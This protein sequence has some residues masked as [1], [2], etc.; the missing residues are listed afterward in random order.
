M[1]TVQEIYTQYR[2]MPFLQLHQLRVAGVASFMAQNLKLAVPDVQRVLFACL[3]H[4]MGN[5]IK[6]DLTVFPKSVQ[7]EGLEFWQKVKEDF[8]KKYGGNEHSAT[9]AIARELSLPTPVCELIDGIGFSKVTYTAEHGSTLAKI[10]EYADM[11]VAPQGIVSVGQRLEDGKIR[12]E[13]KKQTGVGFSGEKY[14][15]LVY[16]LRKVEQELFA[17]GSIQPEHITDQIIG[18]IIEPLRK[19]SL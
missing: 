2:I 4:D 11:R 17:D 9:L 1:K 8:I 7:P 16:S 13:N 12:Y 3:F 15:E 18:M 10:C 6:S 19:L 5:I 14:D